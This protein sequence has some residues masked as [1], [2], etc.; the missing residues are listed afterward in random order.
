MHVEN[1][2]GRNM[3]KEKIEEI[4]ETMKAYQQAHNWLMEL[5]KDPLDGW[6]TRR[7]KEI[8]EDEEKNSKSN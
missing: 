1:G 6:A 4:K 8:E 2:D 3:N 5:S 7:L